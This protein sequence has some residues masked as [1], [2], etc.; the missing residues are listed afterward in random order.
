MALDLFCLIGY[1]E[2]CATFHSQQLSMRAPPPRAITA[3]KR[4]KFQ[5]YLM[6]PSG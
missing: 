5:S 3:L 6:S 4:E 2:D 1:Q